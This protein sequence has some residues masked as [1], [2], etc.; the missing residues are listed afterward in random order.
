MFKYSIALNVGLRTYLLCSL[1]RK[2]SSGERVYTLAVEIPSMVI[3]YSLGSDK[4]L[5]EKLPL[6]PARSDMLVSKTEVSGFVGLF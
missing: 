2:D 6:D 3:R 4:R 1:L 5:L